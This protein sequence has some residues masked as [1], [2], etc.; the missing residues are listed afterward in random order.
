MAYSFLANYWID[1]RRHK[2]RSTK[3]KQLLIQMIDIN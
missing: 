1:K 2:Q 3:R